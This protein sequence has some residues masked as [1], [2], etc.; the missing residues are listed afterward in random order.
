MPA[1][2]F[3]KWAGGKSQLLSE[4]SQRIPERFG[5]Y[6]EPFVG[7]GA[8]FFY[9]WNH[10]RLPYG[11]VLSDLNP[12]LIDCYRAV[13]DHVTE[14]IE[15]LQQLHP[16]ATDR[17]F[18]YEIRAWDRQP[19]FA[20]RPLVERAARTI[21]LNRTCYNG[22]YRLNN[23]GQFNAPFG[24]YK[25][26][27]IVDSDNLREVSRAL[28]SVELRV[29]DF[30]TVIE[31]AQPGD[32]I[33]FDPPYVPISPTASF[34]SYTRR[35]FDETEQRRLATIFQLLAA[36]GCY[37]MLSNSSTTLAHQLY[38]NACEVDVVLA[39]RKI[40]CDGKRRGLVKELIACSYPTAA[41][42]RYHLASD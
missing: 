29:A 3:L 16:Y 38:A 18:F 26:P 36:R 17:D 41:R 7:G 5:R 31:R 1:R 8:L 12:E 15:L 39:S 40:N 32:F 10:G 22:L 2:P 21:F 4:L 35:G 11:A 27:Q 25:N 37:V 30:A 28:S 23:K 34:T 6:H 42:P 14:L 19:N 20:Q 9:L 33:Y 24:Y 13:R